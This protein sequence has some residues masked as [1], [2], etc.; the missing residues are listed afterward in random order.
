MLHKIGHLNVLLVFVPDDTALNI[1]LD[2]PLIQPVHVP[3][4]GVSA[5]CGAGVWDPS[6]VP[7]IPLPRVPSPPSLELRTVFS[8]S[9]EKTKQL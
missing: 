1:F 8:V 6:A 5:W 2:L 4:T 3:G 7:C 9:T